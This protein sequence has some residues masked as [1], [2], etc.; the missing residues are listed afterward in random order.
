PSK[1]AR[2]PFFIEVQSWYLA[3]TLWQESPPLTLHPGSDCMLR[4]AGSKDLCRLGRRPTQ[5][6]SASAISTTKL[7]MESPSFGRMRRHLCLTLA[8]RTTQGRWRRM[9]RFTR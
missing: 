8:D 4:L 3:E 1:A 9:T 2:T 5:V 6:R 7:L